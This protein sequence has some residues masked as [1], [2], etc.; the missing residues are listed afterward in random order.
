MTPALLIHPVWAMTTGC[1]I[2]N[3]GCGPRLERN[4]QP[5][6]DAPAQIA[7]NNPMTI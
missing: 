6:N 1:T 2:S 3:G 5:S 4:L 7:A